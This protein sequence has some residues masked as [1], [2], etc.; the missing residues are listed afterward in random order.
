MDVMYVLNGVNEG[1]KVIVEELAET[2]KELKQI[3]QER[4]DLYY[5]AEAVGLTLWGIKDRIG[6]E[7]YQMLLGLAERTLHG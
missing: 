4:E 3:M 6:N 1:D 7:R 2:L 5:K